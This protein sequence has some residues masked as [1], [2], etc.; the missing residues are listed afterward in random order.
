MSVTLASISVAIVAFAENK[1]WS[2]VYGL[3]LMPVAIAFCVYSLWIYMKRASM[4][5][6]RDPGPYDDRKGPIA[7]AILL[8]VSIVINFFVK[9]LFLED[10]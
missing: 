2:I 10:L 8:A 3:F 1:D 9:I 4:I 5:R 7:L 6:R